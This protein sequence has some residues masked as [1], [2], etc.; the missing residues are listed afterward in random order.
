MVECKPKKKISSAAERRRCRVVLL[1]LR[2]EWRGGKRRKKRNMHHRKDDDERKKKNDSSS[3]GLNVF[4]SFL[5]IHPIFYTRF[6]VSAASFDSIQHRAY[7]ETDCNVVSQMVCE[8]IKIY[9]HSISLHSVQHTISSRRTSSK[10][11]GRQK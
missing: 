3:F 8:V 9:F 7:N 4:H 11:D 2:M 1:G 5:S 10:S 6:L